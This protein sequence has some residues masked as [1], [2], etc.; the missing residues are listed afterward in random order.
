MVKRR[1]TVAETRGGELGHAFF[2]EAG[3][4]VVEEWTRDCLAM[5]SEPRWQVK[6]AG[7]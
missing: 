1:T 3:D 2:L 5:F 6:A 7:L 4:D